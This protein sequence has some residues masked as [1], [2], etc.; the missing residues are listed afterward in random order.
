[1]D[2]PADAPQPPVTPQDHW[3]ERYGVTSIWSG[4]VNATTAAVVEALEQGGAAPGRSLDLGSGEGADVIW[5]A[6]RG[7]DAT[8]VDI[9]TRATERARIAAIGAG[10]PE[11][12]IRFVAADLSAW[13]D[14]GVSDGGESDGGA[15]DGT[16]PVAAADDPA[17]GL[18]DGPFDL[19][20]AS[21]FHSEVEL[22]RTAVLRRAAEAIAVGG[23]LLIVSHAAPP[24]WA[25]A[26]DAAEHGADGAG[27]DGSSATGADGE[28]ADAAGHGA[29][30][31][32][33]APGHGHHD[34]LTPA[35]EVAALALPADAW[36]IEIA[37]SRERE[38]TG[39][40]GESAVL[41]DGVVLL[42]RLR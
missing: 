7:W 18:L 24:P 2:T 12:R 27:A 35:E 23:H 3:E 1:M 4:R 20:T 42:R 29:A 33:H 28:G 15:A 11:E 26:H 38:A 8:G 36:A 21:F 13:A 17:A 16:R 34:L 39:P 40:D 30:G 37:E 31:H 9:S 19:V 5:L 41:E 22:A 10:V 14:G 6:A 25:A 32:G